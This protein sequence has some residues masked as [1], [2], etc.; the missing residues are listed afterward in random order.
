MVAVAINAHKHLKL[1]KLG[2]LA[3]PNLLYNE[4]SLLTIKYPPRLHLARPGE[5]AIA[6]SSH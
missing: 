2:F 6:H 3:L 4:E 5:S 1:K